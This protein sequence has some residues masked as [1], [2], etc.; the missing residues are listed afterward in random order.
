[1]PAGPHTV[2]RFCVVV[3]TELRAGRSCKKAQESQKRQNLRTP[4]PLRETLSSHREIPHQNTVDIPGVR[5]LNIARRLRMKLSDV[6]N[7]KVVEWIQQ[8]LKLSEIQGRLETEFGVIMTYM[9]VKFLLADLELRPKDQE[10]PKG[11]TTLVGSPSVPAEVPPQTLSSASGQDL[12][13]G[14]AMPAGVPGSV[15]VSV[16]ALTKPGAVVSGQVVFSDNKTADWYLDQ[17]G[18]LGLA[19]AE[20]GYKPSQMDVMAFQ[21]ELQTQLAKI[22]Y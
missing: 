21:T 5:R 18:R 14:T 13:S 9:E 3:R 16:D 10:T 7:Q 11:S 1:M 22:G 12:P 20:K 19:P 15:S 8:G 4:A 17:N 2:S 6:Q